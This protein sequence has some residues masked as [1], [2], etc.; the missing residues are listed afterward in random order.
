MALAKICLSLFVGTGLAERQGFEPQE[1][2]KTFACFR[3][4][5]NTF[6][7]V[8]P[9]EG[10]LLLLMFSLQCRR[11][12]LHLVIV[13]VDQWC[14]FRRHMGVASIEINYENKTKF[15]K[16]EKM[17]LYP[18]GTNLYRYSRCI[19]KT[20]KAT[21]FSVKIW[22]SKNFICVSIVNCQCR[23]KFILSGEYR[24]KNQKQKGLRY[25]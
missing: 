13:R 12:Q 17:Y 24:L 8:F 7:I 9:I 25:L 16:G 3:V 10:W 6:L 23:T 22:Q 20:Q 2:Y 14:L 15:I 4:V 18:S 5:L 19:K 21:F 11:G 1:R